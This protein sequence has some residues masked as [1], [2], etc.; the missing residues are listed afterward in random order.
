MPAPKQVQRAELQQ[1]RWDG[2][3]LGETVG[4]PFRV[5]F[6]PETLKVSFANQTSGQNPSGGS[7]QQY[8]GQGKTSLSL[9]LWFDVTAAPEASAGETEPPKDVRE[10]TKKVLFFITPIPASRDR[11]LP[12]GV[13]FLWGSFLFQG[14]MESANETLEFFS[15]EGKPL[16]ASMSVMLTQQSIFYESGNQ[17]S[18]LD[19]AT[20]GRGL[21]A[22]APSGPFGGSG[23]GGGFPSAPTIPGARAPGFPRL[24]GS[25][26]LGTSAGLAASTAQARAALSQAADTVLSMTSRVDEPFQHTAARLGLRDR[27]QELADAKQLDNPRLNPVN[28][29]TPRS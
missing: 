28:L 29:S 3:D 9:D 15:E 24:P 19:G 16:R 27:W 14:I 4:E 1:V 26:P 23:L 12:P 5:Q 20:A 11:F 7:A 18:Q 25:A 6:N 2:Q 8:V 10:L 21:G 13:Q 22:G 17:A